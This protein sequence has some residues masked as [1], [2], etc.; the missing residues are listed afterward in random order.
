MAKAWSCLSSLREVH[1][2]SRES[3]CVVFELELG[4]HIGV[5]GGAGLAIVALCV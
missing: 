2:G 3:G 1:L 4:G 5:T